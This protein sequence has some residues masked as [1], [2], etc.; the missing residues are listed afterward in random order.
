MIRNLKDSDDVPCSTQV[1]LGRK[2]KCFFRLFKIFHT[3]I[4]PII[5]WTKYVIFRPPHKLPKYAINKV[6]SPIGQKGHT[7]SFYTRTGKNVL[8]L[9]QKRALASKLPS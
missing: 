7:L 3:L 4:Y 5:N 8:W 2:G 1:C 9:H 6:I